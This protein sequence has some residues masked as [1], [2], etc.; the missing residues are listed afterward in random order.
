MKKKEAHTESLS[1]AAIARLG[2]RGGSVFP[3]KSQRLSDH[4]QH[5]GAVRA[6][7]KRYTGEGS[8]GPRQRRRP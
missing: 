3:V 8:D 7:E 6:E 4:S 2:S 5:C 1:D